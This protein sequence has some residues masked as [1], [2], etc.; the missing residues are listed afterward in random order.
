MQVRRDVMRR[1][2]RERGQVHRIQTDFGSLTRRRDVSHSR[3]PKNAYPYITAGQIPTAN[4]RA[5]PAAE[6]GGMTAT[7]ASPKA[8]VPR[9]WAFFLFVTRPA[10]G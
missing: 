1:E 8:L 9:T 4:V 7:D 10:R 2:K 5:R 3:S 6:V